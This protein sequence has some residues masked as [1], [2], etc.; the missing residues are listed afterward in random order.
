MFFV[1]AVFQVSFVQNKPY[2]EVTYTGV[3]YSAIVPH[4]Q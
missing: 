2:A 4:S 1:S 3:A